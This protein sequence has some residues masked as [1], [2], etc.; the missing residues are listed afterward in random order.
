MVKDAFLGEDYAVDF[1]LTAGVFEGTIL[2]LLSFDKNTEFVRNA[3][4]K[5][6]LEAVKKNQN[7][8]NQVFATLEAKLKAAVFYHLASW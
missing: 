3:T 6:K 1:L 7:G 8:G 2:D 4:M 5:A